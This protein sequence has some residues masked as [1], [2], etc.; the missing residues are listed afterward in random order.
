MRRLSVQMGHYLL[1]PANPDPDP[2]SR[3]PR[4]PT[5]IYS[6]TDAAEWNRLKPIIGKVDWAWS[7][8]P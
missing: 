5:I 6:R 4:N 2:Q 7:L 1:A 3:Q 8:F